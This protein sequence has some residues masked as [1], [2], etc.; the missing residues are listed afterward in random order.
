MERRGCRGPKGPAR[1]SSWQPRG[2][3]AVCLWTAGVVLENDPLEAAKDR[4]V[5]MSM[6]RKRPTIQEFADTAAFL[7]SDRASGTTASIVNVNSG[8]TAR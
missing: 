8:L 3:R 1:D 5:G 6:L 4:F 2:V 7:A